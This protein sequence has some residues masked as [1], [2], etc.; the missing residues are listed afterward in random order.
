MAD[1][2]RRTERVG[3]LGVGLGMLLRR[4]ALDQVGLFDEGYFMY[5]EDVDLCTRLRDAGWEVWFT[6]EL[7]VDA[8]RRHGHRG[9]RGA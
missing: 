6:P 2:D 9:A 5:V 7:E 3:R 8:R 1:W 4:A